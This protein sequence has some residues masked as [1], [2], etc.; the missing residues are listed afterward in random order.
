MKIGARGERHGTEIF[1][2]RAFLQC[3]EIL[4]ARG[5]EFSGAFERDPRF[6]GGATHVF[7]GRLDFEILARGYEFLSELDHNLRLTVGRSTR[8]PIANQNALQIICERMKIASIGEFHEKLTLHRLNLRAAFEKRGY[9][10]LTSVQSAVLAALGAASWLAL[11]L[12]RSRDG[13][14]PMALFIQAT[15]D[16]LRWSPPRAVGNGGV[17]WLEI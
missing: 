7:V 1:T 6:D 16:I 4:P 10:Q 15:I 3:V 17:P 8:L 2:L 5:E 14:S 9:T 12:R 13:L 11:Q